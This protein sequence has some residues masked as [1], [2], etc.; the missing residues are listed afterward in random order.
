MKSF[1]WGEEGRKP[2]IEYKTLN[3]KTV[4]NII[5]VAG[6]TR[7]ERYADNELVALMNS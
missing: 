3:Q 1:K 4:K 6:I 2:V 7:D 5:F